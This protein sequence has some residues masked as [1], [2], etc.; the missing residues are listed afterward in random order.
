MSGRECGRAEAAAC[1]DGQGHR[2]VGMK[3]ELERRAVRRVLPR[4][5]GKVVEM[6]FGCEGKLP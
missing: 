6:R 3:S 5:V 4:S 2:G 1:G